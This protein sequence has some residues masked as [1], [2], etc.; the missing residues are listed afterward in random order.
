MC[1]CKCCL[2]DNFHN[3]I[4]F[5]KE[6]FVR[7]NQGTSQLLILKPWGGSNT[8]FLLET[9]DVVEHSEDRGRSKGVWAT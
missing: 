8:A 6:Y 3:F 1:S 7:V 5:L 9:E 4:F 2:K